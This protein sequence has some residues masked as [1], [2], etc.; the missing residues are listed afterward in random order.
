MNLQ[1][2]FIKWHFQYFNEGLTFSHVTI[3]FYYYI[4]WSDFH[5]AFVCC[6]FTISK[7]TWRH[8]FR[9]KKCIRKSFRILSVS[10]QWSTVFKNDLQALSMGFSFWA[11]S[12][13]RCCRNGKS[14]TWFRPGLAN[15]NKQ[16]TW[17]VTQVKGAGQG[18]RG[19]PQQACPPQWGHLHICLCW[20]SL[21]GKVEGRQIFQD[22]NWTWDSGYSTERF[23]LSNLAL[24]GPACLAPNETHAFYIQWLTSALHTRE[25]K[26]WLM[27]AFKW[28]RKV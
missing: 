2:S 11:T 19:G 21:W 28:F 6:R 10:I 23:W 5:A 20:C 8:L 15:L 16:R 14:H 3:L 9:K 7:G 27:I 4:H 22:S 12:K 18:D 17:W 25:G 24:S 1:A 26:V 13:A